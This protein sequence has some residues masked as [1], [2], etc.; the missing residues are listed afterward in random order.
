MP[1][2]L[3]N[4][5][6]RQSREASRKIESKIRKL[7]YNERRMLLNREGFK[8]LAYI[9]ISALLSFTMWTLILVPDYLAHQGWSAQKIG[10]AMGLFFV[11]A[12]FSRIFSGH[13]ADRIGNVPTALVGAGI[14]LGG[15]IFY[16]VSLWWPDALFAA[17]ALHGAGASMVASGAL[18]HLVRSVPQKLKGRVMGYFGLPGFVMM[19]LGPFIAETLHHSWGMVGVFT[20]ILVNFVAVGILLRCLPRPLAPKGTRRTTFSRAF[21]ES[22]PN[23]RPVIFF[24]FCFGAGLSAWSS[25]LAPTVSW[26]GAGAVS[27]F[28]V[29]YGSGALMTRLGLSQRLDRGRNRLIAISS[30]A[31]YGV[32]LAWIPHADHAW[33]LGLIGFGCGMSHGLYYPALSSYAAERFHP[34]HTGNAMSLYMSSF[35]LGMFLGSPLW[36]YVGNQ[37]GYLRIF[38]SAGLL[39]FCSTLIFVISRSWRPARKLIWAKAR[40]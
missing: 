4:R 27:A 17:R 14:A 7:H 32:G 31:L 19:G 1:N 26:I 8:F 13:L 30:L 15:C 38:A 34:L 11:F 33:Q 10:W 36:G 18:F 40:P 16:W 29:G 3:F 5:F 23:L 22:F 24:A 9:S 6:G 2:R 35:S 37:W 25:F 20:F 12:L 39:V 28:G 21:K